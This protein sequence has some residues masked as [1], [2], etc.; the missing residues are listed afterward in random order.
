[1]TNNINLYKESTTDRVYN[2]C[3]IYIFTHGYAPSY[4]EIG[5]GV[6]L[7]SKSSVYWHMKKLFQDGRLATDLDNDNSPRA[8][9]IP[10][11]KIVPLGY[12]EE[13]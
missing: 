12:E 5:D 7:K 6:G 1:M 13:K 8:F 2:F 9:R 10:G 3:K 11:Y 4:D